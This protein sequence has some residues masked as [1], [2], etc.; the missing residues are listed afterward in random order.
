MHWRVWALPL[1]LWCS[2]SV[3]RDTD[4]FSAGTEELAPDS[5]CA[6]LTEK[7]TS[8]GQCC[9]AVCRG[10]SCACLDTGE[11]CVDHKNCCPGKQCL[12]TGQAAGGKTC[13]PVDACANA[14]DQSKLS[15][16][17]LIAVMPDCV[18]ECQP[19]ADPAAC[20]TQC[21]GRETGLTQDCSSCY[22]SW[23]LCLNVECAA[24]CGDA[25]S[26]PCK[27]CCESTCAQALKQCSGIAG[28]PG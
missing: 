16:A 26:A 5:G 3:V 19:P 6:D 21:V 2:C 24:A 8:E 23:W 15:A 28:C 9:S 13:Q 4:R 17:D 1:L 11:A 18:S 22:P 14:V 7:C 12:D 25:R 20:Q 27:Q 10:G